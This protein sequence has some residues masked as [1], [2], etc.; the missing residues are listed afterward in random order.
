M[1]INRLMG[2][3]LAA[4]LLLV[5]ALPL[6]AQTP[7]TI[8][9][10]QLHATENSRPVSGVRVEARP[11][12]SV[13]FLL[14]TNDRIVQMTG[15]TM[16]QWQIREDR[17]LGANPVDFEI[18]GDFVWFIETG[19]SEI[20]SNQ[21]VLARLDT[22]NGQL[23]EWIVTG[24]RPAG[25]IRTADNRVWLPQTD[26]RI[27]QLDLDTRIVVDYRSLVT[28]AYSDV[29]MGPDGAL[30]LVDFGN[31]RIVRWEPGALTETAWTMVDPLFGILNTTQIDFDESGRLWIS[32][33]DGLSMDRFDPATGELRVFGGFLRPIH[34]DVF[35]G[36]LYVAEAPGANGSVTVLDPAIA[37]SST[38]IL[39]AVTNDVG[40]SVN[41]T[42][43]EVRDST[44]TP[45]TFS[46]TADAIPESDLR[47]T[48]TLPGIL[49]T[50]FPSRNAYG[51]DVTGG[52]VWV[53]S[54]GRLA[55][56]LLQTVGTPSD[57]AV[58]VASQFTGSLDSQIRVDITL[59]NRG[60]QPIT[61]EALYLF[62]P[63]SFAPRE[64]FVLA[65]GE[66]RVIRDAF[67]VGP[68]QSLLF[69]PVRFRVTAG[70]AA[71]LVTSVRTVRTRPDGAAFGYE[72]PGR[73]GAESLTEGT[74]RTLFTGS[75]STDISIFGFFTPTGAQATATLVAPDGTVRGS[76]TVDVVANVAQEFNPAS[77]A[78]GVSPQPGDVIRVTVA[79][80]T[81]QPYVH[82]FQ[83]SSTDVAVS[84]PA[85]A[86]LE[87]FFPNAGSFPG[88][89]RSFFSDLL[90]SNPGSAP[91]SLT[92]RFH[93]LGAS[94]P[95][96]RSSVLAAGGSVVYEDALP[97]LF[98]V[99]AG[100]GAISISSDAPVTAALRVISR[101]PDG[102]YSGFAPALESG[103]NVPTIGSSL[104]F[105]LQQTES[106]RSHLLLF[107]AGPAGV[108]TV[109]GFDGAGNEVGRLDVALASG[110]AARVNAVFNA[111]GIGEMPGGSIRV[112]A[113]AGM[114]LYAET[115]E[116]DSVT[117][118]P[119]YA[120]L[121]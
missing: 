1:S 26:R 98:G 16:R 107:N 75:R 81:L 100:Q 89:D 17:D 53:G 6:A 90:L 13:W 99:G 86:S 78:F 21:S 22:R 74:T 116:L 110:E 63:A 104:S 115:A 58:P 61:G 118:D 77:S 35:N 31:N 92:L 49:R 69:G 66:T 44:I 102:D 37:Q 56:L 85:A 3:L 67:R 87:S 30:W 65:P 39:T 38:R 112:S 50:E 45:T 7:T 106:R 34:F 109:I 52:T 57:L 79:S 9:T 11:D 2:R 73:A 27:Q 40:A 10:G 93:P 18:D 96:T 46:T 64:A 119:E 60:A 113:T 117:S 103:E 70:A 43:A 5:L 108:A 19:Q 29:V 54:E 101:L 48:S 24:S 71:D 72:I 111:L 68:S 76:R 32:Q 8:P 114:R 62:S 42:R 14:P 15:N 28:V 36:R 84:L 120:R 95:I 4:G 105:G 82:V 51:I 94:V 12:G 23:R 80:G 59:H 20:D 88:E 97:T 55:R 83:P 33:F 25:F 47:V 121:R 41:R 91:A